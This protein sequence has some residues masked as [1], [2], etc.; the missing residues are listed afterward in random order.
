MKK[1][2][3]PAYIVDAT[4]VKNAADMVVA[5]KVGKLNANVP[6]TANETKDLVNI[7]VDSAEKRAR[8]GNIRLFVVSA[9]GNAVKVKKPNIFKR[10]WNWITRKN[11]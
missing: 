3:K 10:F 8:N 11:K 1:N 6:L 9:C 4:K 7:M 5:L 2:I